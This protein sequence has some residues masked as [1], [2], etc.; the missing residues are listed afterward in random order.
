M[1]A[2]SHLPISLSQGASRQCLSTRVLIM[3]SGALPRPTLTAD[4]H[5]FGSSRKTGH[6]Q[7]LSLTHRAKSSSSS[8]IQNLLPTC[9]LREF[10]IFG[11]CTPL[12]LSKH[13]GASCR[14]RC[15]GPAGDLAQH[16]SQSSGT[17]S[18]LELQLNTQCSAGVLQLE[19]VL[20]QS[21]ERFWDG[22]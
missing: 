3:C 2:S 18:Q 4:L 7:S 17:F 15:C 16:S 19:T 1:Q 14:H 10:G 20:S 12:C 5:G 6:T 8:R 21:H 11:T 13:T 9:C 22:R